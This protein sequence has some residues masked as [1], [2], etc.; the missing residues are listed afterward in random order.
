MA[1]KSVFVAAVVVNEN[2]RLAKFFNFRGRSF[3]RNATTS[4]LRLLLD[5]PV[6]DGPSV[7]VVWGKGLSPH[8]TVRVPRSPLSR[9]GVRPEEL[10]LP[11]DNTT[12]LEM[13]LEIGQSKLVLVPFCGPKFNWTT[14]KTGES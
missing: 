8:T 11:A 1:A 3:E 4:R 10:G 6:P 2:D 13:K 7:L 9:L 5:P 14:E 12:E